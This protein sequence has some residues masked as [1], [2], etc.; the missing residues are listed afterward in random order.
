[1]IQVM[2]RCS[3]STPRMKY[4]KYFV[5]V[6]LTALALF[7]VGC[8]GGSGAKNVPSTSL[9]IP[10]AP[11]AMNT[12]NGTQNPGYWSMTLDDTAQTF[13]YQAITYSSGSP[14]TGS[15]SNTNGVSNFGKVNGT[16]AGMAVEVPSRAAILRPGA[17][18]IPPVAMVQQS[19]C[20]AFTDR[21]RFIFTA[22]PAPK[23]DP[24]F[25]QNYVG[26]GTVV[27]NTSQD[28]KSWS[29]GDLREY[30]LPEISG[31][32]GATPGTPAATIEPTSFT[33]TCSSS[34][35]QA[36]VTTD[37][38]PAFNYTP[39][40]QI[41]QAGYFIEDRSPSTYPNPAKQYLSWVGVEMPVSPLS[42]TDISSGTY[43]GFAYEPNN[44]A[45]NV[46]TQPVAFAPADGVK[47]SLAGGPYPND[48]LSQTPS[49]QYTIALGNQ[50]SQL[51]G[52]FPNAT[53]TMPDPQFYCAVLN[54]DGNSPV[55]SGFDLNGNPICT[56][57]GVAIVA[58]PETKYVIYFTSLD[59][60]IDQYHSHLFQIYLYQQ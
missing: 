39:T 35:G 53:L 4:K 47:G 12:Y 22:M 27:A 7:S 13:S 46:V 1:M 2:Q 25:N 58:K 30:Q 26:Y 48:D 23:Q 5:W 50:D 6:L 8:G 49:A 43:T 3:G 9:P 45:S 40:F 60:T 41:N 24:G 56:A 21:I 32:G 59:G 29:F 52:V 28:G 31:S 15:I 18:T 19:S 37:A 14:V 51:N 36:L 33:A 42:A 38:N 11:T 20:F 17:N 57:A 10:S 34:N 16:S 54:Q 44:V 55:K